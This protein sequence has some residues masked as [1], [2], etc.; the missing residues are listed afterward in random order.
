[1]SDE[2][3]GMDVAKIAPFGSSIDTAFPSELSEALRSLYHMR[4][5]P[6][7]SPGPFQS[8]DD[9]A[10]LRSLFLRLPLE[11]CYDMV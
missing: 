7:L 1:M 2:E 4:R 9:K 8:P 5:G 11:D 3:K 6:L 10:E